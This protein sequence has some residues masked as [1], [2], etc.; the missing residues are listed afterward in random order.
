MILNPIE[1]PKLTSYELI[2][3]SISDT[4][5][6]LELNSTN[7]TS[8]FRNHIG[9]KVYFTYS[10]VL[11]YGT[12]FTEKTAT[13]TSYV[14]DNISSWVTLSQTLVTSDIIT[15]YDTFAITKDNQLT[16]FQDIYEYF[17]AYTGTFSI[18]DSTIL[19]IYDKNSKPG[20][21]NPIDKAKIDLIPLILKKSTNLTV[22]AQ[23]YVEITNFK[24]NTDSTSKIIPYRLILKNDSHICDLSLILS[25]DNVIILVNHCTLSES[26]SLQFQIQKL[27]YSD[28][29]V[30]YKITVCGLESTAD[31]EYETYLGIL[32]VD[33][34]TLS[35]S[36]LL[37]NEN[38][39]FVNTAEYFLANK[40]L[41]SVDNTSKRALLTDTELAELTAEAESTFSSDIVVSL[42]DDKTLGRYSSGDTIPA[43]GKTAE[44]VFNLIAVE[45]IEPTLTLTSSTT[46]EFNQTDISNVLSLSYVINSLNAT[47]TSALLQY[48]RS[49]SDSW[50]TISE[51]ITNNLTFTH[52]LTDSNYNTNSFYYRY[53]V[54]DSTDATSTVELTLTPKAYV[55]PTK[56]ISVTA[57][58]LNL[59]IESAL[60]REVGNIASIINGTVTK[61]S[62]NVA[63]VSI[64]LEVSLNG[65]SYS[66]ILDTTSFTSDGSIPT[67][68]DS[69]P[70]S[71]TTSAIYRL[72]VTDEYASTTVSSTVTFKN[73]IFY[74]DSSVAPTTSALIRALG[75]KRFVDAGNIF[76]LVT[77]TSN[78]IFTIAM[79]T[80]KSLSTVVD[81]DALNAV[82]TSSYVLSTFDVNDA[83]NVAVSYKIYTMTNAA[84]Y[85]ASHRHQIT[86]A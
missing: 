78:V 62:T 58:S 29:T 56:T 70:T 64:K 54:V 74:G 85:S 47:I 79:P 71:S 45:P 61:N 50:E 77:G 69:T 2:V 84:P 52:T 15:I 75:T 49:T 42:S 20:L 5:I 55:A 32:N 82:I 60:I 23:T 22:T 48:R 36:T 3:N 25:S 33:S 43:K 11:Y 17:K 13:E 66:T 4:K 6:Y 10:G 19:E 27:V 1:Y 38:Q 18:T 39:K 7:T 28:S 12:F 44:E 37:S 59:S 16:T 41:I 21:L 86:L 57:S 80:S 72:T 24:L 83:N 40:F 9:K 67:T 34:L 63:L 31:V 53:T 8:W 73:V 30:F 68:N 65:G 35:T 14:L 76:N 81:L 26:L 51:D 46:I